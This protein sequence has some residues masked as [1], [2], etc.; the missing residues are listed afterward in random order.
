MER[1]C[2]VGE[3]EL[4]KWKEIW[5]MITKNQKFLII[6]NNDVDLQVRHLR[7]LKHLGWT[8]SMETDHHHG[9]MERTS[10]GAAQGSE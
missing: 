7:T 8:T 10:W 4:K 9:N 2:K 5:K 6:K 3:E 1:T